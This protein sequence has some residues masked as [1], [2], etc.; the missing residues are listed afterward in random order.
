V[1]AI[2]EKRRR[3][4]CLSQEITKNA[5]GKGTAGDTHMTE[6]RK[7]CS[8]WR[9]TWFWFWRTWPGN[10]LRVVDVR[11]EAELEQVRREQE[12]AEEFAKNI[13]AESGIDYGWACQYAKDDY[14]RIYEATKELDAKADSVIQY[15]SVLSALVTGALI[16]GSKVSA[17]MSEPAWVSAILVIAA[18]PFFAF[19]VSAICI[20]I[21]ARKPK[22]H[23]HP[24]KPEDAVRYADYHGSNAET[25]FIGQYASAAAGLK[26]VAAEKGDK[27]QRAYR[28]FARA[29]IAL[30]LPWL[31]KL[32]AS[33]LGG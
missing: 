6:W 12:K 11:A 27:V 31:A 17:S 14:E 29:V 33:F 24:P 9:N 23:P 4:K 8:W 30:S 19:S 16:Y 28:Q 5:E 20:A 18:A 7:A 25:L 13:E 10:W 3:E 26:V 32:I 15:V 22:L 1:A 2:E 21:D